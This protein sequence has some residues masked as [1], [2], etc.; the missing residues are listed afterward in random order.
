VTDKLLCGRRILVVEDEMMILSMLELFLTDSGCDSVSAAATTEQAIDLIRAQ[1]FDAATL[2]INL[3]GGNSYAVAD[4][5]A[6]RN[7]P[8]VFTTGSNVW[9]I[10]EAYRDRA[11]LRKPFKPEQLVQTLVGFMNTAKQ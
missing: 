11:V 8:F 10:R 2:D 1:S 9:S 4:E 6:A 7:V 3:K 5:L